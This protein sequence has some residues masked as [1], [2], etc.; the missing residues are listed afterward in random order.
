MYVEEQWD[1]ADQDRS[2]TLS[3]DEVQSVLIRMNLY[4]PKAFFHDKFADFDLDRNKTMDK[5]EFAQFAR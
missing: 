3:R 4:L 2:G 5:D 1:K